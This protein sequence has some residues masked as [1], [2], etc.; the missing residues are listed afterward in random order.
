MS[1]KF[2]EK[3]PEKRELPETS[4]KSL[5][6]V[7]RFPSKYEDVTLSPEDIIKL[8]DELGIDFSDRKIRGIDDVKDDLVGE[9]ANLMD[10]RQVLTRRLYFLSD[11]FRLHKAREREFKELREKG[12]VRDFEEYKRRKAAGEFKSDE[13][14]LEEEKSREKKTPLQLRLEEKVKPIWLKEKS[15][16]EEKIHK[17]TA[18]PEVREAYEEKFNRQRGIFLKA[19]RLRTLKKELRDIDTLAAMYAGQTSEEIISVDDEILEGFEKEKSKLMDEITRLESDRE[20]RDEAFRQEL[21]EYRRQWL[22]DRFIVTPE[23]Q[24]RWLELDYLTGLGRPIFIW[25][26]TGTAKSRTVVE[27]CKRRF[28]CYPEIQPG[29]EDVNQYDLFGTMTIEEHKPGP[30]TR[31]LIARDGKGTAFLFDEIDLVDHKVLGELHSVIDAKPGELINIPLLGMSITKGN[32]WVMFATA[33]LKS[34]KYNREE[35]DPAFLRRFTSVE[36]KYLPPEESVMIMLAV[37]SDRHGRVML[38]EGED[39][40]QIE[41]LADTAEFIQK[42]YSGEQEFYGIEGD[43]TIGR[44]TMLKKA[45]VSPK[46]LIDVVSAW[47]K[48]GFQKSLDEIILQHIIKTQTERSDQIDLVHIFCTVGGFFRNY[49]ASQFDIPGITEEMLAAWRGEREEG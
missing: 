24:R 8:G 12:I 11:K 41:R 17:L 5:P 25:G 42:A 3:P 29:G 19:R 32:D 21:V 37:L 39:I 38:G 2:R 48:S 34:P 40:T 44:R 6:A 46:D 7:K 4:L 14:L 28:N 18:I 35:M 47:K 10:E 33:N 31:S 36:W 20:V 9:L 43:A 13:E 16:I 1:T 30:L 26:H 23:I 45:T 49:S 15:E 22:R 27:Y